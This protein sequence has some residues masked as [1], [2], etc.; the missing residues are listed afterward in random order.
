MASKIKE[1]KLKT[2]NM[3][4]DFDHNDP[5]YQLWQKI[6]E[7]MDGEIALIIESSALK[8][9][10]VFLGLKN[11]EKNKELHYMMEQDGM[12]GVYYD[13]RVGFDRDW[14][15]GKYEPDGCYYLDPENVELL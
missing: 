13:D 12:I 11:E 5:D 1:A 2:L 14:D 8:G 10:Y 9:K 15:S 4:K 6:Y 3:F 7:Y